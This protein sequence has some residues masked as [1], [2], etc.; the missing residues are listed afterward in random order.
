MMAWFF[1][2][3]RDVSGFNQR[4]GPGWFFERTVST[5]IEKIWNMNWAKSSVPAK[6]G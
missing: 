6:S 2:R 1:E 5:M 3:W 4:E